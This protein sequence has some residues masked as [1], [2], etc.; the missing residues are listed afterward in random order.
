MC[1]QVVADAW[2]PLLSSD[3]IR[4]HPR[5]GSDVHGLSTVLLRAV[6]APLPALTTATAAQAAALRKAG[7][8]P[9][10]LHHHLEL[11]ALLSAAAGTEAAGD[12][13]GDVEAHVAAVA[14]WRLE[15][16]KLLWASGRPQLAVKLAEDLQ[17]NL[18][19]V[20]DGELQDLTCSLSSGNPRSGSAARHWR[21]VSLLNVGSRSVDVGLPRH[22][23]GCATRQ[24]RVLSD[25]NLPP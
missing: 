4:R 6:G 1:A 23:F 22:L 18:H 11:H 5:H 7:R 9:A 21:T 2:G 20:P 25:V 13:G 3:F 16:A 8:I 14:A 12:V 17:G 19:D 24:P 10:A 15:E